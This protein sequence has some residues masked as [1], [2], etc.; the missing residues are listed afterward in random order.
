[1]VTPTSGVEVLLGIQLALTKALSS[2]STVAWIKEY[3]RDSP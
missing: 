3:R 2:V 1:V